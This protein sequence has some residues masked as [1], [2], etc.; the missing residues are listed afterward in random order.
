MQCVSLF[1]SSVS[2][3][4]TPSL[5]SEEGKNVA[6]VCVDA[7]SLCVSLCLSV[8]PTVGSGRSSP[9][10]SIPHYLVH[11]GNTPRVFE[12]QQSSYVQTEALTPKDSSI[13]LDQETA[14]IEPPLSLLLPLPST[15]SAVHTIPWG[16][17]V[18]GSA[19]SLRRAEGVF[20]LSSQTQPRPSG[21]GVVLP[22]SLSSQPPLTFSV[23]ALVAQQR[24]A[25]PTLATGRPPAAAAAPSL[26]AGRPPAPS[27]TTGRPPAP[28]LTTGRPPA[29]AVLATGQPPAPSLATGRPPAPSLTTGRPPAAAVLATGQPPAPTL[30]TGRPPAPSLTTG[31]P[32]AAA[33]LATGRPPAP[34]LATGRPPAAAVLAT[35]Q[36]PAP[37]LATGRP[38]APS[39]ATGRPPAPSLATGRPPAAA[40][41]ATGQPPAPSLATGRPPAPSLTTGRPPAPSLTAA[42]SLATGRPPAPAIPL[43]QSLQSS[44]FSTGQTRMPGVGSS[45]GSLSSP[46]LF[47]ATSQSNSSIFVSWSDVCDGTD[48]VSCVYSPSQNQPKSSE[49]LPF[50]SQPLCEFSVFC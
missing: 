24:A 22:F 5:V 4:A 37:S 27:L 18:T 16:A 39:L 23:S 32:P 30:A 13:S 8:A 19:P 40:V 43:S 49:P 29:A 20:N 45:P 28:S 44:V 9:A 3:L 42:A 35:G 2:H 41:L 11:G 46:F 31:R 14:V 10:S 36:P 15:C 48:C 33:V 1:P 50:S 47:G 12:K 26:T 7:L 34:S 25:A 6:M 17:Q 38:P 21:S